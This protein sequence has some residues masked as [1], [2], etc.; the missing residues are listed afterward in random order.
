MGA[1]APVPA[2]TVPA[3]AP[4]I[5]TLVSLGVGIVL[6]ALAIFGGVALI[7]PGANPVSASEEV[8]R[9]DAP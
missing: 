6:A 9:Y 4:G 1:K 5:A 8:V 3:M 7:T 2:D